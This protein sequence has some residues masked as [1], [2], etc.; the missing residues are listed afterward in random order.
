MWSWDAVEGVAAPCCVF[1]AGLLCE[2]NALKHV[3]LACCGGG[4]APCCVF[5][6]GLLCEVNGLNHMVLGCCGGGS[7]R[8]LFS[9]LAFCVRSM[10]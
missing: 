6:A 1:S 3:V 2:V 8:A 5:S 4:S 7:A 9:L 10:A